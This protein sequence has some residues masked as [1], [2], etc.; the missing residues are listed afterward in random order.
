MKIEMVASGK[1]NPAKYNP[2]KSLGPGDPEYLS[3]QRSINEFGLVEPLIVNRDM[4]LISGH[5]RLKVL[6]EAGIVEVPCVFVDLDKRREAALNVALNKITGKWDFIKLKDLIAEIDVGEFDLEL[7]GFGESELKKIY[8]FMPSLDDVKF[9]DEK[10][11][12]LSGKITFFESDKDRVL[13]ELNKIK[14]SI[15]GFAH[16]I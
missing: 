8:D 5:Q 13:S 9:T 2:R 6:T 10:K 7:T 4:T 14:A 1:I 3:I 12:K 15:D 11:K 16:Y